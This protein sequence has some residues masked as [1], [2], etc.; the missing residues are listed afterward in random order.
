MV[1]ALS[2][3]NVIL[4]RP[5]INSLGAIIFTMYLIMKYSL[6][7]GP[8]ETILGDQKCYQN[9]LTMRKEDVAHKATPFFETQDTY[10]N[11]WDLILGVESERLTPTQ[12]LN[13]V[14]IGPLGHQVTK[15][16]MSLSDEEEFELINKLKRN[17]DFVHLGSL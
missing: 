4:G 13:E 2:P 17:T 1:D 10:T 15:I 5:T 3:Y 11:N 8:G 14:Q 16:A 7:N 12:D 9:S 6:P